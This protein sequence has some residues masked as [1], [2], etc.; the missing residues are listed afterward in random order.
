GLPEELRALAEAQDGILH[1][2]QAVGGGMSRAM[3]SFRVRQGHWQRLHSGVYAVHSGPLG[4]AAI[5]WAA[6]LRAGDG[7]VLSHYTAAEVRGLADQAGGV[8][9]MTVPRDRF[10][11]RIPGVLVH[12]STRAALAVHPVATPP[13]TRVEET[14]LDL[15]DLAAKLDEAVGWA[16][17]ALGRRLT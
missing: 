3:I 14:V 9:H 8:V 10:A 5:L 7:A 16:T 15:A 11:V 17:R 2:D 13:R 6:L 1:R 4:R 12:R